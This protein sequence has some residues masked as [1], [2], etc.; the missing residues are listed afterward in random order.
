[1]RE[2]CKARTVL[3]ITHR[4]ATLTF[5]D[6]IISL[7]NGALSRTGRRPTCANRTASTPACWPCRRRRK[8][9]I[10]CNEISNETPDETPAIISPFSGPA[11]RPGLGSCGTASSQPPACRSFW[12][13]GAMKTPRV[14]R[15]TARIGRRSSCRPNWSWRN[16]W[17]PRPDG[18]GA[19][20]L[21]ALL[22][23]LLWAAFAPRP[24]HVVMDGKTV[25]PAKC[26]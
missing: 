20:A 26:R 3:I 9:G 19:H 2:I 11:S 15:R 16:A 10:R 6:R 24:I 14:A 23:A 12:R 25:P 17:S 13:P 18:C 4:L 5:A 7:D 8:P 1:M 22:M 21:A